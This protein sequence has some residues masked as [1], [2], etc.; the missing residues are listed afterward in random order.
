MAFSSRAVLPVWLLVAACWAGHSAAQSSV[1]LYGTIDLNL[2]RTNSGTSVNPGAGPRGVTVMHSG[3]GSRLGLRGHE[4]LGGGLYLGFHLEH[5]FYADTGEQDSQTFFKGVSSLT[6]GST[7]WGAFYMGRV[8]IPAFAVSC[9][10]EPTCWSFTSEPGQAYAWAN[11]SG[12]V[13]ADSSSIRR[14]NTVGYR[15]PNLGGWSSEI[16]YTAGEGQRTPTVGWNVQYRNGPVYAGL[17]YDGE[18]TQTRLFVAGGSYDFGAVRSLL[19]LA[20]AKGG[21]TTP[22]YRAQS[23]SLSLVFPLSMGRVFMGAGHLQARATP[24]DNE[25]RSTKVFVGG[26]YALSKRTKF[27]ANAGIAKS[28]GLTRSDA[29]DAGI[30]HAF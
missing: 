22:A 14:N 20:D 25:V 4:D 1:T 30:R 2:T 7:Q 8:V 27:Y 6:L 3:A 13:A 19:T 12:S 11:Y 18:D 26:E 28:T 5:R 10:T 24:A 29:Y 15:S 17:G 9:A 16:A 21:A 23:A